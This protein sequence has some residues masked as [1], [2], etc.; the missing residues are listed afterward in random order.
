MTDDEW[1]ELTRAARPDTRAATSGAVRDF[2]ADA[3]DPLGDALRGDT[4]ATRLSAAAAGHRYTTRLDVLYG[5][6][7]VRPHSAAV[8]AGEAQEI[9]GGMRLAG[10][11]AAELAEAFAQ[12]EGG[13]ARMAEA[14]RAAG[15]A[16]AAAVDR[17]LWA[18]VAGA[19]T[20]EPPLARATWARHNHDGVVVCGGPLDHARRNDCDPLLEQSARAVLMDAARRG[21]TFDAAVARVRLRAGDSFVVTTREWAAWQGGSAHYWPTEHGRVPVNASAAAA[22]ARATAAAPLPPPPAPLAVVGGRRAITFTDEE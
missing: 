5:T 7:V 17:N 21:L 10:T 8:V 20:Y 16:M 2:L 9:A 3:P 19:P 22:L 11:R 4:P 14:A 6:A 18:T 15:R 1:N 13:M 12:S